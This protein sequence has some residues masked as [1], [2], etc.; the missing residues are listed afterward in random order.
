MHLQDACSTCCVSLVTLLGR[1]LDS[2]MHKKILT[3]QMSRCIICRALLQDCK[4]NVA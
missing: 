3:I 2:S 1:N 4:E